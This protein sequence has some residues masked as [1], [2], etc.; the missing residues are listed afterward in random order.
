MKGTSPKAKLIAGITYSD[1]QRY[2]RARATLEAE[3]GEIEKESEAFPFDFTDYYAQEMGPGLKKRFI[4]FRELVGMERLRRIKLFTRS[5]EAELSVK[6][7]RQVNIDP[8]YVTTSNLVLASTKERSHRIYLG[9]GVYA[10]VTLIFGK[11]KCGSLP[12]TYP[13]YAAKLVQDFFLGVR[14]TLSEP[15]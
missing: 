5:L 3:F 10:E 8:G 2:D 11:R 1:E 12:W 7:K 13:D 15:K 4:A 14:N 6:G 9:Q